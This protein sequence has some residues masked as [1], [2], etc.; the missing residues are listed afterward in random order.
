MSATPL[1]SIILPT[2]NRA[3]ML[4]RAL[5]SIAA[6]T[7]RPLQ[8][9]VVDDGSND[10]TDTTIRAWKERHHGEGFD[11]RHVTQAREGAAVAR[12]CGL[13]E[14]EGDFFL[15]VDD[16]HLLAPDAVEQLLAAQ[17]DPEL[18]ALTV[19]SYGR[20]NSLD[21]AT[22]V[23]PPPPYDTRNALIEKLVDGRWNAPIHAHLFSRAALDRIGSWNTSLSTQEE[24]DML[25]RAAAQAVGFIAAPKARVWSCNTDH[26][27]DAHDAATR[28]KDD[29]AIRENAARALTSR[30]AVQN[31]Q[32]A[33]GDWYRRLVERYGD[34]AGQIEKPSPLLLWARRG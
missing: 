22:T 9:V 16:D 3:D 4:A 20:A 33:F 28:M 7:H 31:Y 1:I 8:V 23:L 30:G 11:V 26:L 2:H 15:F 18:A 21:E 19:A 29:I 13:A 5:D 10:A 32:P 12:N 34:A 25:L 6:Q 24:D 27:P 14:C 17:P